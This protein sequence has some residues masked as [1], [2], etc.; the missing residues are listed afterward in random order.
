MYRTPEAMLD[1]PLEVRAMFLK[2]FPDATIDDVAWVLKNA[3]EL[4][5]APLMSHRRL[6]R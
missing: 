5:A 2:D 3:R 1:D 4:I 6:G